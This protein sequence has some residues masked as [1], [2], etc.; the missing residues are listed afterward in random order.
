MKTSSRTTTYNNSNSNNGPL[1]SAQSTRTM[2]RL[3][4]ASF[5]VACQLGALSSLAPNDS[6][7]ASFSAASDRVNVSFFVKPSGHQAVEMSAMGE[8]GVDGHPHNELPEITFSQNPHDENLLRSA[9]MFFYHLDELHGAHT[10]GDLGRV[11]LEAR[12]QA[13]VYG[14]LFT[15]RFDTLA[16]L[17]R[18]AGP[19]V[20]NELCIGQLRQLVDRA[21]KQ[22]QEKYLSTDFDLFRLMDSWGRPPPGL[23]TGSVFFTGAHDEC[24]R[25]K[26]RL[27]GADGQLAAGAA[28]AR[29]HETTTA[30][31]YCVLHL[32]LANWPQVD[33]HDLI[34]LKMGVCL[35][36]AC[37]SSNYK[38]KLDLIMRLAEYHMR[39]FDRDQAK[40]ASLYCLP[41]ENS[42]ARSILYHPK[43]LA[44][45]V[46]LGSWLALLAFATWKYRQ[47]SVDDS[48]PPPPPGSMQQIYRVLSISENLR[49]LFDTTKESSLLQ[50]GR[51]LRALDE[52]RNSDNQSEDRPS[53]CVDLSCIEGVKVMAMMY[54]IAAHVLMCMTTIVADSRELVLDGTV[55]FVLTNLVPAFAV[56][57][58]FV[59]TG[60]LTCYL[61]LK[62]NQS[63]S[64]VTSPGKWFAFILYR[65]LRIMPVYALVVLYCKHLARFTGSGP[66][67]DYGTTALGQRRVCEQES[68]FWTLAFAANFKSSP[69]RH[70]IPGGWYLANDFQF[71][72][73]TPLLLAVLHARPRLGRRLLY[74]GVLAG[75]LAGFYSIIS[76]QLDDLRPIARFSPH[77]FKMYVSHLS[78]NYTRPHY[79]IP[80]YLIGLLVGHALHQH[81]LANNNSD[82][83]TGRRQPAGWSANFRRFATP[84]CVGLVTL[85][86]VTP[87]IGARL[88]FTKRWAKFM[89]ALITP[90]YHVMFALAVGLYLLLATTRN[91][92]QT[93]NR[94]LSARQW[95][96]LARLS[97][98]ALLVNVETINYLVQGSSSQHSVS[99]QFHL[100][101]NALCIVSTYLVSVL[102]CVLFE[103]PIRGALNTILTLAVTR[104]AL[105][106]AANKKE[107]R[108]SAPPTSSAG[109]GGLG[110][111]PKAD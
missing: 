96:P 1:S 55:A 80:A 6:S 70:C 76:S 75:F 3:A 18:A 83:D 85:C 95:K 59:I 27:D 100:A 9:D 97:L 63:H 30:L 2:G 102:V 68:W 4:L 69:L 50:T 71:S 40:P 23:L 17:K 58:F 104:S 51:R 5:I 33:K 32:K 62:Q 74:A 99:L 89:V 88:P 44:S 110:A 7:Q 67:W 108:I 98:C 73:V 79:R 82:T 29:G 15:H 48:G 60:M 35:P 87:L 12:A 43:S 46:A 28:T 13:L 14:D 22:Q 24:V 111:K 105:A 49:Q 20:N 94:L 37:D 66:L 106:A 36:K 16:D 64:F 61:M 90:G 52:N 11:G 86:C 92:N 45:L 84:V 47:T 107:S 26:I 10:I 39:S 38:N 109:V 19:Q 57:S 56:N 101:L 72:L 25:L 93:L 81:E 78:F 31:R 41:D 34:N 53:T 103:A 77:G 65:Y 54:V 91:G 21:H 42:V 8:T